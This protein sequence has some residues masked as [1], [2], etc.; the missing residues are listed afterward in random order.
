MPS[1][2]ISRFLVS[3]DQAAMSTEQFPEIDEISH[4]GRELERLQSMVSFV[5]ALETSGSVH[6]GVYHFQIMIRHD[7]FPRTTIWCRRSGMRGVGLQHSVFVCLLLCEVAQ[8]QVG[9]VCFDD[10]KAESWGRYRANTGVSGR[11]QKEKEKRS[12]NSASI[13]WLA[14]LWRVLIV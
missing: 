6:C 14:L 11:S 5:L 2:D 13:L 10:W 9:L 8:Q 12:T 4:A 7:I 1:W 3:E